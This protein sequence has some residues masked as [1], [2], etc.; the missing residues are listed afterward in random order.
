MEIGGETFILKQEAAARAQV[1]PGTMHRWLASAMTS[2][3]WPVRSMQCLTTRRYY[4]EKQSLSRL[5]NRFRSIPN[6]LPVEVSIHPFGEETEENLYFSTPEAAKLVGV[7]PNAMQRWARRGET[8]RGTRLQAVQD[9]IS[10]HYYVS[11]NS[12]DLLTGSS[13]R[14]L[15]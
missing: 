1:H 6:G 4:I 14:E 12:I 9:A 8:F 10:K 5:V 3:G 11:K 7:H 13:A 2:N 15:A